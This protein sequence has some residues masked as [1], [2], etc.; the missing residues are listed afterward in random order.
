[1]FGD[2]DKLLVYF[3]LNT[4]H[5]HHLDNSE[6]WYEFNLADPNL[7]K[8]MEFSA[9]TEWVEERDLTLCPFRTFKAADDLCYRD[10]ILD[11]EINVIR[12]TSRDEVD[13]GGDY[14]LTSVYSDFLNQYIKNAADELLDFKWTLLS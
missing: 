10:V 13:L 4:A 5:L 9:E 8:V 12:L 3:K 11:L 2:R 14:L 1:M 6:L 7:T